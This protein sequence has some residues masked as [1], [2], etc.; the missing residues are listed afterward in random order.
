MSKDYYKILNVEKGASQDNIKRAY[1][2]LAHQ[3]HPDKKGGDE[4]KFKEINEAYQILGDEQKRKQ[5]DQYGSAGF[6]GFSGQGEGTPGWD[7][8]DFGNL[9]DIFEE[10]F[11][12]FSAQG[13]A[14]SGFGGRSRGRSRGGD[15]AL[16]IDISFAES[17][18]GSKRSI[19]IEK[20]SICDRCHGSVS[21]PNTTKKRCTT[22]QG[23]G[24]V[25]ENRKSIFGA[26]A[27]LSECSI[28]QGR[29]EIPEKPCRNCNATGTI[30]KQETIDIE[31][32]AGIRD[33]EAIKLTG[34]GEAV[35]N[36]VPGDLYVRIHVLQH[37][38]FHREGNDIIMDLELSLSLMLRGGEQIIE[39]LDGKLQVKIPELSHSGD[40]LRVR[41]R[42]V[43]KN[44]GNRGDLIIKL[45]PKFPKKL[46]SQARK[47]FDELEKEG[48]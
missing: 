41:G 3:H 11:S 48:F 4:K 1:R 6:Q 15:I 5:Y 45:I 20:T 32:P 21:E 31:I 24:T 43:S 8:G 34:M 30:R 17:V 16:G 47:L 19:I 12:G 33:G 38:I 35:V 23:S 18:F 9:G 29:G 2:K 39:T 28:C 37:H 27:S 13:G 10:M 44:R 22:C 25:R 46:S 7:F 40:L 26:F 14:Y 42:G 36:G